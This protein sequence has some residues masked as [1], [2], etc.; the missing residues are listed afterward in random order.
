M[1]TRIKNRQG[2]R[3]WYAILRQPDG[4]RKMK[5]CADKD[6][7]LELEIQHRRQQEAFNLTPEAVT[8]EG[9][10]A[11]YLAAVESRGVA[12]MSVAEKFTIF[13]AFAR[14]V[15]PQRNVRTVTYGEVERFLGNV[16]KEKSGSRAN[17]YRIH[18]VAA[19][20]WGVRGMGLPQECPW[21]VDKFREDKQA[22]YIPPVEDFW[23]VYDA[24][25]RDEDEQSQRLLMAY[26][27]TAARKSEIFRLK[28]SDV[29]F[30]R[31][32]VRLWTRKRKGGLESNLVPMS[33]EL[34]RVLREQRQ[35]VQL[36]SEYVF[37]SHMGQPFTEHGKLMRRLCAVANVKPF[38]FHAIRHLSA[39]ILA[40]A[41]MT[42][43]EI[44]A[45]LR[46]K[47]ATTTSRYLH[48]LNGGNL[49]I[50]GVFARN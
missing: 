12:R 13:K 39:S 31:R 47:N 14:A 20:N 9:L 6:S 23:K 1:P 44:Q 49:Q 24:A 19:W 5:K 45:M 33:E 8:L 34:E 40:S 50:D 36:R 3:E 30:E 41:S 37:I 28:W 42:L 43:P 16:A 17:R 21:K 46:H 22:R 29:D 15:G 2:V 11:N 35:H 4:S 38:G 25:A 26:L 7:A 27:H 18:I 32:T 10:C 48:T